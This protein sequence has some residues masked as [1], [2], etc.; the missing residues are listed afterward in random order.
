MR[1]IA[2]KLTALST[3]WIALGITLIAV[4]FACDGSTELGHHACL[5]AGGMLVGFSARRNK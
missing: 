4:G 5:I 3:Q 2:N 1:T